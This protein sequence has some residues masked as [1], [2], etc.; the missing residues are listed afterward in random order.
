MIQEKTKGNYILSQG[1]SGAQLKKFQ[2]KQKTNTVEAVKRSNKARCQKLQEDELNKLENYLDVIKDTFINHSLT[3]EQFIEVSDDLI[4]G[5]NLDEKENKRMT[6]DTT[7]FI[8]F[9]SL[10]RMMLRLDALWIVDYY[11][12]GTVRRDFVHANDQEDAHYE[13][14]FAIKDDYKR[15]VYLNSKKI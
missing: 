4:N 3:R 2:A 1:V 13:F 9:T 5:L 12:N 7:D 10:Y 15:H 6:D 14:K 11:E 8:N